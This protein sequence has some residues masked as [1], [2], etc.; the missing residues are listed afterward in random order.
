MH[1]APLQRQCTCRSVVSPMLSSPRRRGPRPGSLHKNK[2]SKSMKKSE[3]AARKKFA[4]A[5]VSDWVPAFAGMT[6]K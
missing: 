6:D 2:A 4:F 3:F 1:F 5:T